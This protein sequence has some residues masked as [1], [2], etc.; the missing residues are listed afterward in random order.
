MVLFP[1]GFTLNLRRRALKIPQIPRG[2]LLAA[3]WTAW[4][5]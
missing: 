3:L 1:F 5:I 2:G 4:V